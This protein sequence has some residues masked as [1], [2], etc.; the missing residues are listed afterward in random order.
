MKS[1]VQLSQFNGLIQPISSF[2]SLLFWSLFIIWKNQPQTV[3]SH[4][5]A[6]HDQLSTA[7]PKALLL[8]KVFRRN[9]TSRVTLGQLF[10]A[11]PCSFWRF[12]E[13]QHPKYERSQVRKKWKYCAEAVSQSF[14]ILPVDINMFILK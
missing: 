11:A 4:L 9:S 12:A 13:R 14:A 1:L 2:E 10:N 3:I 7:S 5:P 8:R 6:W